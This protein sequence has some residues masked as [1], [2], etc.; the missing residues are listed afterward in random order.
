MPTILCGACNINT[1][2]A[3]SR[4]G[5]LYCTPCYAYTVRDSFKRKCSFQRYIIDKPL[6]YDLPL[7]NQIIILIEEMLSQ[8][9]NERFLREAIR[10]AYIRYQA[11]YFSKVDTSRLR[12][13]N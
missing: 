8:S 2:E 13:V 4:G 6:F 5:L 12:L 11:W 3:K 7:R 1:A 9:I 10:S